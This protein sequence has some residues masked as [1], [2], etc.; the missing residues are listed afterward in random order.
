MTFSGFTP[1]TPQ[2]IQLEQYIDIA[3]DHD[4]AS[5]IW[6]SANG[7]LTE[8]KVTVGLEGHFTKRYYGFMSGKVDAEDLVLISDVGEI[9]VHSSYL[10]I[11]EPD[12]PILPVCQYILDWLMNDSELKDFVKWG[13]TMKR[14]DKFITTRPAYIVFCPETEIRP[15]QIGSTKKEYNE[16]I[17]IV[18]AEDL[19]HEFSLAK[20]ERFI[21]RLTNYLSNTPNLMSTLGVVQVDPI[22]A[23]FP[24]SR[25]S[26]I[27]LHQSSLRVRVQVQPSYT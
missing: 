6:I 12:D 4:S 13:D 9:D 16:T 7:H 22:K 19:R 14:S 20:H 5:H 26:H 18:F 21:T 8:M 2:S 3:V 23:Q 10:T 1:A 11:T 17:D 15:A 25:M 27:Y 24:D